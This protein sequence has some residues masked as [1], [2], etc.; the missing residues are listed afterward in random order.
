[1]NTSSLAFGYDPVI[2][3]AVLYNS[4]DR[5]PIIIEEPPCPACF[6][7]DENKNVKRTIG[8]RKNSDFIIEL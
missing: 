3:P 6:L 1:M 8:E 2:V 5:T 7:Q 4:V